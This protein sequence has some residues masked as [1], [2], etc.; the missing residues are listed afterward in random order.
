MSVRELTGPRRRGLEA[1]L[2]KYPDVGRRSNVTD[3]KLGYVYWQ[4]A[5]WLVAE[6]LAYFPSGETILGLTA[7]GL[8]LA[9]GRF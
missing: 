7:Q 9:R 1:L 4:T 2:A 3:A 6:G 5:D 8:K